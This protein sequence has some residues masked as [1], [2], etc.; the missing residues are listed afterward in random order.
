MASLASDALGRLKHGFRPAT[1]TAYS[2]MFRDFLAFLLSAG[3][4]FSQVTTIILLAFMEF[5]HKNGLSQTNISNYMAGI[6]AMYILH[7]IDTS[8][9]K[10][11]RLS[12]FIKSLKI[13]APFTPKINSMVSIELLQKILITCEQLP[14]PQ[15]FKALYSF[16]FFSF[17][18]LSNM[19]PH[20][21]KQ[22]DLTRHL[23]RGD[24]IFSENSA[25][26]IVKW[27]KTIQ[28]RK[29]FTTITIPSLGS[30]PLCPIAALQVMYKAIPLGK[31]SPLFCCVTN[32]KVVPLSDS[33]ARKHLKRI[34][35]ILKIRPTLTFHAFRHSGT[36]WAF[37]NGVPLQEIMHHGTWS[38]NA[39][40][41]YIQS[42]PLSSSVVSST[43]QQHL[44]L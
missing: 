21:S 6:R 35:I 37:V 23:T 38:S 29:N 41:R 4:H 5:L 3:L 17:L 42:A 22:F 1:L 34:S 36:T 32:G 31:N 14:H 2:R 18:R 12:L 8:P 24:L 9:F 44:Q 30:S 10:D 33:T 39:V 26:I 28:N 19:L 13:N 27:S 25:V 15:V 43:F 11:D 7:G 40:W 16:A 20:S